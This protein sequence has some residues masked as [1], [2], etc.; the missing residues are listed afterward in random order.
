MVNLIIRE[1]WVVANTTLLNESLVYIKHPLKLHL[2][3]L[4]FL[5][6]LN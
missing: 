3:K 4:A 6:K 5:L 1:L 2:N